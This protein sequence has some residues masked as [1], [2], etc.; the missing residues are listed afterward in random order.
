[1]KMKATFQYN[2]LIMCQV[3]YG[4]KIYKYMS[5]RLPEAMPQLSFHNKC[6]RFFL[7]L[8]DLFRF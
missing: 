7:A 4:I 1:M 8:F 6:F 5:M 2:A 3:L